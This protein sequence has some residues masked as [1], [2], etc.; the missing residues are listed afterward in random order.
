MSD[1]AL[2]EQLKEVLAPLGDVGVRKTFGELALYIDK[3]LTGLI[4]DGE[5]YLKTDASTAADYDGRPAFTYEMNGKTVVTAY[6]ALPDAVY[7]DPAE[8]Q[9]RAGAAFAIAASG[10]K[11]K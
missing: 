1:P 6:R 3:C 10:K 8:L 5:L 4:L 9:R 7:D 2:I 11:K